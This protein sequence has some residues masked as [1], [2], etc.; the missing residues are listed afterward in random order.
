L[1]LSEHDFC[2]HPKPNS[3]GGY[4]IYPKYSYNIQAELL[5]SGDVVYD[6]C[7]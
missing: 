5:K 2:L 6:V 3:T 1:Q 4:R 7:E